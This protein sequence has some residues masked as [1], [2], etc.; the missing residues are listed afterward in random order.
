MLSLSIIVTTQ[1][2]LTED[3]D[4]SREPSVGARR[5]RP[6]GGR[7][8]RRKPFNCDSDRV[9]FLFAIYEKLTA[10]LTVGLKHPNPRR[11]GEVVLR[12]KRH[13]EDGPPLEL[14]PKWEDR[15]PARPVP[16]ACSLRSSL[17]L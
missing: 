7:L 3:D 4:H 15:M 9:E 16:S 14:I 8:L 1:V 11:G 6:R 2:A 12:Q 13:C 10:P 5:T 17:P